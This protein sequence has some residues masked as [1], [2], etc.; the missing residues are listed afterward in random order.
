MKK[1]KLGSRVKCKYTGFEGTA[2]CRIEF[3]N[4]CVQYGVQPDAKDNKL[5]EEMSIDVQS[6]EVVKTPKPVKKK[7]TGGPMRRISRTR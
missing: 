4:G 2:L 6:L 5:E 7:P 1:I 3:I